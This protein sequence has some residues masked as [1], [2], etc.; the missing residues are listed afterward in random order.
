MAGIP[1]VG[2][3]PIV[4]PLFQATGLAENPGLADLQRAMEQAR[5]DYEAYRPEMWAA[6]MG[7]LDKT[8]QMFQPVNY[9][10]QELYGMDSVVPLSAAF[11]YNYETPMPGAKPA[12]SQPRTLLMG[13]VPSVPEGTV[14]P[15]E[16]HKARVA[17]ER[18]TV[19][20]ASQVNRATV[21]RRAVPSASQVNRVAAQR[22]LPGR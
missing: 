7:A 1:L 15:S 16:G 3:L 6:R 8:M 14:D 19:P 17:T 22:R 20:S 10:M 13:Q 2:D 5:K 11:D 12:P 18:R 21:E 9:K 4:G